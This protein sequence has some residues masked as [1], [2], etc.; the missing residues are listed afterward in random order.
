MFQINFR[1][2][3]YKA[4]R[5][6]TA[7]DWNFHVDLPQKTSTSGDEIVTR[8]YNPRTRQWDI[9]KVKYEKGYDY[10]PVLISHM[11]R[12][13]AMDIDPV[14]TQVDLN[15]SDPALISPTIAHVPPPTATEIIARRSRFTQQ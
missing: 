1:Y 8:K 15:K 14:T 2:Q 9:K 5:Q 11:M 10:I 3:T 4:R 7:I 13:R 6:L 12:R